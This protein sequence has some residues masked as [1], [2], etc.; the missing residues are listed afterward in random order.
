MSAVN[1][2]TVF[3][4]GQECERYCDNGDTTVS[5]AR[6]YARKEAGWTRTGKLDLCPACAFKHAV[7]SEQRK[8][9]SDASAKDG[10]A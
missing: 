8:Q 3:C 5:A 1:S 10:A 2:W 6:R 9:A 7:N 4:D